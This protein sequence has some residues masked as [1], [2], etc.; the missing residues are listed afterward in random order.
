[1]SQ[2]SPLNCVKMAAEYSFVT[3]PGNLAGRE[4]RDWS[5]AEAEEFFLWF[6]RNEVI[7]INRLVEYVD[8]PVPTDP[9]Q[10]ETFLLR[11]GRKYEK[12]LREHASSGVQEGKVKLTEQGV[13]LA[14]DAGI[15]VAEL[16]TKYPASRARWVLLN[17]PGNFSH[18]HAVVKGLEDSVYLDPVG[19]I[20]EARALVNGQKSFDLLQQT[21]KFW[22]NRIV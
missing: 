18:H 22:K 20:Y 8:E 11:F 17:D 21:F 2:Q 3:L 19:A 1:M 5:R 15:L 13:A 6:R 10:W 14:N 12:R 4:P 7:R 9:S 16:L